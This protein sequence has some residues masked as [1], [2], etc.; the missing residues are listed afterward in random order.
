MV[1]ASVVNLRDAQESR[2]SGP[3]PPLNDEEDLE[4]LLRLKANVEL[5]TGAGGHVLVSMDDRRRIAIFGDGVVVVAR[6]RRW[7]P[8]VKSVLNRAARQEIGCQIFVEADPGLLVRL[9][10]RLGGLETAPAARDESQSVARQVALRR[11]LQRAAEL[12]ASD[13][14]IRVL[15]AYTEV[16][17]RVFG[18]M[19][20][21]IGLDLSRDEGVAMIE[22]AYAVCSDQNVGGTRLS[23]RQGALTQKSKILP[24]SVELVRLQYSPTSDQRGTLVARLKY[25]GNSGETDVDSL[26][27]SS[28]QLRDIEG[29]RRRTSGMYLLAG[30]VSS[31]KSTTLQKNL[32]KMYAETRG[33]L[34]FYVIEDPVELDLPGAT[35]VAVKASGQEAQSEA[36]LNALK[37]ALR[38]DPNVIVLGEIRDRYIAARAVEAAMTGHALWSTIHAGSALGILDRLSDMEVDPWKLADPS[39]VRGLVYQR[40]LGVLCENCRL[41]CY[42]AVQAGRLSPDLARRFLKFTGRRPEQVFVRGPGCAECN[43][44][45]KGRTVVAETI[46]TDTK[47][48]ELYAAGE[49]DKMREHWL[50]PEQLGGLGGAPVL[51]HALAKAGAGIC[52]LNEV[53]QEVDLFSVYERQHRALQARLQEDIRDLAKDTAR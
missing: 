7:D 16:K 50:L 27:Y 9:Y 24:G 14:H 23:F 5:V 22:A 51:H 48:L 20:P 38:S 37:A 49:R 43:G 8:E 28:K 32:N 17:V 18:R 39:I 25:R 33:E 35:Q 46:A 44:G 30:R 26:G 11:L 2:S 4:R 36:F 42:Q 6:G 3:L 13:I 34:S 41:D 19:T 29:M 12:H 45:L 53:E 40:L 31:G 21:L 52:D 1:E 47:L 15:R 10:E